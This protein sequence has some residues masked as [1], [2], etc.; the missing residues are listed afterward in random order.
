MA[1][2]GRPPRGAAL[3]LLAGTSLGCAL[4]G[5]D[6]DGYG[7]ATGGAGGSSG[8]AGSASS[9][10][11]SSGAENC[12]NGL[13]D[14]GDGNIDCADPK[15]PGFQCATAAPAGWSGPGPLWIGS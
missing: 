15:C 5:Y 8:G 2:S 12:Q 7:P 3:L 14:D 10:S 13:D 1:W 11:S 4:V 6:F 9:S